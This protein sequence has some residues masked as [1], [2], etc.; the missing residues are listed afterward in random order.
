MGM[1]RATGSKAC[2]ITTNGQIK[3]DKLQISKTT[4]QVHIWNK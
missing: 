2:K 4:I 1:S 3:N